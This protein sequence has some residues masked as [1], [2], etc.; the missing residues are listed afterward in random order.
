[1]IKTRWIDKKRNEQ[2][3]KE[4][5]GKRQM[6]K[7]IESTKTKLIGHI[8]RHNDFITNIFEE[9]VTGKKP[10]GR[11]RKQHFEH[12]QEL[13]KC[14]SF[15]SLKNVSSNRKEWLQRQAIVFYK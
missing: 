5:R 12:I 4:V 2:V 9:E 1:M 3:L 8:I 6:M 11:L 15:V 14:T 7:M 13:M 10:R